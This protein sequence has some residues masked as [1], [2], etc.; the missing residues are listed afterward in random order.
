MGQFLKMMAFNLKVIGG[1]VEIL[2]MS[3]VIVANCVTDEIEGVRD[4]SYARDLFGS[5]F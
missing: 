1:L 5:G 3:E 4:K 2:E